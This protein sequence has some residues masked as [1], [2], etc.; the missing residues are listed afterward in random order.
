MTAIVV[1]DTMKRLGLREFQRGMYEHIRKPEAILLEKFKKPHLVLLP[2]KEYLKLREYVPVAV[3]LGDANMFQ[4]RKEPEAA[5]KN[6][7]G[8]AQIVDDTGSE[9]TPWQKIKKILNTKIF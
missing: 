6:M 5:P 1:N 2:Y 3:T 7:V 8:F 9:L 4:V